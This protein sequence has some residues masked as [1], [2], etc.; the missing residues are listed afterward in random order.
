MNPIRLSS[1]KFKVLPND[2]VKEGWLGMN[3]LAAKANKLDIN[4][5]PN[6]IAIKYDQ[7]KVMLERTKKHEAIELSAMGS[8]LSYR[9]AHHLAN[10]LEKESTEDINKYLTNPKRAG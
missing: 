10:K 2:L 7:S 4:L 8:G 9:S 1:L 5:K 6:E 3:A